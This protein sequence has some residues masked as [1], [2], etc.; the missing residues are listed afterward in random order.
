MKTFASE[1]SLGKSRL[2]P[3]AWE[4][5]LRVVCFSLGNLAWVCRPP[6]RDASEHESSH[7]DHTP[8]IANM[9]SI[10]LV[11]PFN[12]GI[13]RL[14]SIALCFHQCLPLS[15]AEF[16]TAW[17]PHCFEYLDQ[18]LVSPV[19]PVAVLNWKTSSAFLRILAP[20]LCSSLV[21]SSGASMLL[22]SGTGGSCRWSCE[23]QRMAI[24]PY[25]SRGPE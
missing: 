6:S 14:F 11:R 4:L 10:E 23:Y 17:C 20:T 21:P 22:D 9:V 24:R 15:M 25:L 8:A 7:G 2:G 13:C 1:L 18:G 19:N 5:P 12:T 3:I 16:P